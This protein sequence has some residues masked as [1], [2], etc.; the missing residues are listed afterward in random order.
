M[1][2]DTPATAAVHDLTSCHI[3]AVR[4]GRLK[5]LVEFVHTLALLID[6][7]LYVGKAFVLARNALVLATL[8][9]Q[10]LYDLFQ[11]Y[12]DG[13]H[14]FSQ[15]IYSVPHY[16]D[17]SRNGNDHCD[18]RD[19]VTDT[20]EIPKKFRLVPHA[21]TPP[22]ELVHVRTGYSV[23]LQAEPLESSG[24]PMVRGARSCY[25]LGVPLG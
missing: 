8:M 16:V 15:C 13:R 23:V 5:A 3:A 19:D 22:C 7:N 4:H 18:D 10:H 11:L 24:F 9:D 25:R 14:S 1:M 17:E 2:A 20:E 6:L 12:L 21:A